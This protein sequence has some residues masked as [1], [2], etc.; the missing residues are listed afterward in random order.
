M[1]TTDPTSTDSEAEY[2]AIIAD[3]TFADDRIAVNQNTLADLSVLSGDTVE[4]S[5][6]GHSEELTVWTAPRR[7]LLKD[8]E[9]LLPQEHKRNLEIEEGDTVT[10]TPTVDEAVQ[11]T[12]PSIDSEID[13]IKNDIDSTTDNTPDNHTNDANDADTD[14]PDGAVPA[15]ERPNVT[16]D[17]IGGLDDQIEAIREAVELPLTHPDVF[18]D[19]GIDAPKGILMHGPPGT[20][21]T[22][23]AKAI[24]GEAATDFFSVNGPE[25]VSKYKGESEARLRDIFRQARK[26]GPAIIFFDEIDSIA[27][28]RDESGDSENRIVGQLL[29]LMDGTDSDD[30]VVVIGATNRVDSID[31]ALRRGGRFDR[32]LE[33]GVPDETGR[34]KI[35][36]IHTDDVPMGDDVSLESLAS[37][38]H[39]F[40]GADLAALSREAAMGALSRLRTDT[41][42]DEDATRE[43]AQ[44]D[45]EHALG[46]VEPSAM[47]EFV[48]ETPNTS[49]DDVGGL[50]EAKRAL[51]QSVEWP[52]KYTRI[53]EETS[54][55]PSSGVLMHGP[56]GTGKT[57]MAR[58]LA[59]TSD[60]NFIRVDS[61]SL[62]D[63]Y[64]G[65]SEKAVRELFSR[66]RQAS[67]AIL[68]F[69]EIDAIAGK[70]GEGSHEVTERVVSQLLTELDGL[71]GTPNV[72]VVAAT[73]RKETIDSSLLRPGR[74]EEELLINMPDEEERREIFEIHVGDKPLADDVSSDIV[75]DLDELNG[76]D[77]E[78]VVRRASMLAIDETVESQGIEHAN[79]NADDITITSEH[80]EVAL[81]NLTN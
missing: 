72:T 78:S 32:E 2:T 46:V 25:I 74:F 4:V 26:N 48:A 12:S 45:F 42:F 58:A 51:Q 33:I 6:N 10:V 66:A 5:N 29:S 55:D 57:L 77:I 37:R 73:S 53:F 31:P 40:V 49:F 11:S 16:Y 64:V 7:E 23:I 38:T 63:K 13:S 50:D 19:F 68:F 67:P 54:T 20:G 52:L 39:G 3:D 34:G 75:A 35:L 24:A 1:T 22:L 18:E 28:K 43:V 30:N 9:V 41:G 80:F 17:D 15:E 47:R 60:V 21:K 56:S 14:L 76:A 59:G 79:Q 62:V 8:A 27:P 71:E 36:D 65:E 81:S 69:D 61:A 44:Q 70:R